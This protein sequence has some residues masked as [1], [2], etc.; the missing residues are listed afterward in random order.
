MTKC[1]ELSDLDPLLPIDRDS[2]K[3]SVRFF[4]G[5]ITEEDLPDSIL[6]VIVENCILKF[7]DS[8]I[9]TNDV[10][11]CSLLDS[12]KYL[13]RQ[14]WAEDGSESTGGLKRRKE[15]EGGVEYE[16]EYHADSSSTSSGWEK[17]YDYFISNPADIAPCLEEERGNTFGLISIGGTKQDKSAEVENN[18]NNKSFWGTSSIGS[19]FSARREANRRRANLRSKY[20]R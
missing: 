20:I 10:V 14:S 15:K 9:Y 1:S 12:L 7:E 13:I 8:Q 17:L 5:G 6:S 16:N 18:L 4:M 3:T 19:K 2:V 11:Y